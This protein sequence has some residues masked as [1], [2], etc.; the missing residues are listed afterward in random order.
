M[1]NAC[2]AAAAAGPT[3]ILC[4]RCAAPLGVSRGGSVELG[5]VRVAHRVVLTC[6]G[7]G[8]KRSWRPGTA[9]NPARENPAG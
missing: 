6:V 5:A 7:C 8:L 4:R 2:P 9:A 1:T 3:L